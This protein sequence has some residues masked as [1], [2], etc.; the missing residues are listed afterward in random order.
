[1]YFTQPK[2][3]DIMKKFGPFLIAALFVSVPAASAYGQTP[4]KIQR[5]MV[6]EKAILDRLEEVSPKAVEDFESGTAALDSDDYS[7]GIKYYQS[8][9][10]LAPHFTPAMRRLGLCLVL[11]DRSK[12]GLQYLEQA[13]KEERSPENLYALADALAHRGPT[14]EPSSADRSRALSLASE[15]L[16]SYPD[17]PDYLVLVA[18]IASDAGA[19]DVFADTTA[20]LVNKHPEVMETH[21]FNAMRAAN[22]E[23]WSTADSEIHTAGKMGLPAVTVNEFMNNEVYSKAPLRRYLAV[24]GRFSGA[25]GNEGRSKLPPVQRYGLY[26]LGVVAM[27]VLGLVLLFALGKISFSLRPRRHRMGR[28]E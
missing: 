9:I 28:P 16:R 4:Q 10:N 12:E 5:D 26:A 11:S 25:T 19:C 22:A 27:C 13:V 3:D 23:D 14:V 1:M 2:A 7:S 6:K 24:L 8:V 17:N 15:A 21:F 18:D 20:T